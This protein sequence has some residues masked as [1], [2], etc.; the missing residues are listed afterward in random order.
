MC[1]VGT[2]NVLW[3]FIILPFTLL[4]VVETLAKG[5]SKGIDVYDAV[6]EDEAASKLVQAHAPKPHVQ[7]MWLL[8][9]FVAAA[10]LLV[11]IVALIAV[12]IGLWLFHF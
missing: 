5:P 12:A 6:A 11:L 4:Q 2:A 3:P 7:K 8:Q 1:N 9:A 10:L